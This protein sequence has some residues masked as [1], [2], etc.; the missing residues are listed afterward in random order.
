[1][2]RNVMCCVGLGGCI[3]RR[4]TTFFGRTGHSNGSDKPSADMAP[5]TPVTIQSPIDEAGLENLG[6]R[7]GAE[8]EGLRGLLIEASRKFEE[9]DALKAAFG[10]IVTPVGDMLRDVE[11]E[12]SQNASLRNL[13]APRVFESYSA[14]IS[15]REQQNELGPELVRLKAAEIVDAEM[16]G[17]KARI[18]VRFEAELAEGAHGVREARERWTFERDTR[19]AD[20]NW[21]LSR[22]QAA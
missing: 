21:L 17:D 9:L 7:I 10:N 15:K 5:Q 8:N 6:S 16:H 12:K 13:L 2:S 14:A 4:L 20:P 11:Q 22:V 1:M 18:A 3:M 19:S